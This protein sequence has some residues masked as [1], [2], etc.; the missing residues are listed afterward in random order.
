MP[1]S[2]SDL[3]FTLLGIPLTTTPILVGLSALV[4]FLAFLVFY[5]GPSLKVGRE[6]SVIA[7]KLRKLKAEAD[8]VERAHVREVMARSKPLAHLWS[9]YEET[10]HDQ[11]AYRDGERVLE[12]TRATVP[13]EVFFGTQTVVD[14]RVHSEFFR[15][16]PGIMTGIGIIG[17]FLGL[18]DGLHG[19]EPSPV[20][21]ELNK[22]LELLIKAVKEAF[23]ASCTAIAAAMLVTFLEK[24]LINRNY[25][26]LEKLVQAI[27]ALYDAGAGEEY[28]SRLVRS[29]EESATQ[30]RQLKDSLLEDLKA[31]LTELTERQV[32]ATHQ[33]SAAMA[34]NVGESIA[35]NLQAPLDKIA[36]VVEVASGRQGDAVHG[37]LENLMTAFMAKLEDTVGDQMK[38]LSAMMA[39]SAS[40]M[41]EMQAGFQRLAQDLS[42]AG[43]SASR[44]M[45][46][47][48]GRMMAEAEARQA[49][50]AESLDRAVER[51]QTQM[52]GGQAELQEKLST[53]IL[54]MKDSVGQMLA[55]MADQRREMSANGAED[56]QKLKGAMAEMIEE[57]RKASAQTAERFGGELSSSLQKV[58]GTLDAAL[59]SLSERQ[60]QADERGQALLDE[61]DKRLQSLL[62]STR[63]T[64]EALRDNVGRLSQIS[65]EA[66][67]G[68]NRGAETMRQAAEGFATAG[69]TVTGAVARGGE[70]FDRVSDAAKGLEATA[71]TMRDTVAAYSQTRGSLEGMVETLRQVAQEA[72]ARAGVSRALLADMEQ[73]VK[74]FGETQAEARAYL[75]QVSDVLGDAFDAFQTSTKTSLDKNRGDFDASL[76]NAVGMISNELQELEAVLADFRAKIPA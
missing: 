5:V 1:L 46:D 45:S 9:E 55:D 18:I 44:S 34:S 47:Q 20:P 40:S 52:S 38:G 7:A 15:H 39:E 63:S 73:L 13:A 62:E 37:M 48:L 11:H 70:L 19:F 25:R 2:L 12:Q 17:T 49:R 6:L 57:V 3:H 16:L 58:Q 21:E 50:M 22:G 30:T 51:M 67:A 42:Q 28:L 8:L 27:D 65:S 33:A 23:V 64:N 69:D 26:R 66:I 10:L 71:L 31:L 14:T 29:S 24:L 60:R 41:R 4:L 54:G 53:A 43:D 68:M 35:T 56:A 32:Q 36:G 75:E 59:G 72:D 61:L 76:S 74:R